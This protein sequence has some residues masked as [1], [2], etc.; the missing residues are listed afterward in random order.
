MYFGNSTDSQHLSVLL[1]GLPKAMGNGSQH[2]STFLCI[3]IL[4][5]ALSLFYVSF[6]SDLRKLWVLFQPCV[7]NLININVFLVSLL[8]FVTQCLVT[9]WL[10]DVTLFIITWLFLLQK[11]LEKFVQD[12]YDA[13]ALFLCVHLILRYQLM[14]HKRAV[15]A[16]DQYWDKLQTVIWPRYVTRC[17][18][19]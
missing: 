16:L 14:C 5:T 17:C 2:K 10:N 19:K 6:L 4:G 18:G 12:C 1:I 9:E 15:P 3:R 7:L 13:I 11:N 8:V